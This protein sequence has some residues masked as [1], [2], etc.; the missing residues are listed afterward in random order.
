[1]RSLAV[2]IGLIWIIFWLYWGV[3]A[4]N[5]KASRQPSNLRRFIATRLVIIPLALGLA[6]LF[7]QLPQ[8][9]RT[10]LLGTNWEVLAAGFII[11]ILGS[12]LA[13]WARV[14]LGR[15]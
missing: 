14:Y 3:S 4:L 13:V 8:S 12:A 10:H 11:F 7:K 1:M 9:L 2:I 15:N 6:L 5:A